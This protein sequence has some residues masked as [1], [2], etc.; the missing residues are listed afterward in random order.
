MSDNLSK[1]S[2]NLKLSAIRRT[3]L[4][5]PF[6]R[7]AGSIVLINILIYFMRPQY[8][9]HFLAVIRLNMIWSFIVFLL[10]LS[11]AREHWST[12]A[13]AMLAFLLFEGAVGFIGKIVWDPL[14]RND[15]QHFYTWLDLSQQYLSL[16]FPS[17]VLL[18]Y[19]INLLRLKLIL[20]CLG[21]Y[22]GIYSITHTGHGPGGFLWDEND[23]CLALIMLLPFA[24]SSYTANNKRLTTI[25]AVA[26][27]VSLLA[28]I[29]WTDSR[30]GFVGLIAALGYMLFRSHRKLQTIIVGIFILAT[31][32]FFVPSSYWKEMATIQQTDSGT[33]AKRKNLWK[34]A[35]RIWL[36]PKNFLTGVG[37]MNT[38]YVIADYEPAEN[39]LNRG[40]S[41]AGRAV[42]SLYFQLAADLGLIGL[43]YFAYIVNS[44][45]KRNRRGL[46][47]S[48]ETLHEL[49]KLKQ[50]NNEHFL[51][52]YFK[53]LRYELNNLSYLQ[54]AT[55]IAWVGVL[56]AGLFISVT[57]YPVIWFLVGISLTLNLYSKRLNQALKECF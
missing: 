31:A 9:I 56:F 5:G 57:Y 7:F 13:K 27:V 25:L 28:G 32:S 43:L 1:D 45:I 53:T 3:L 36:D 22:L 44:S 8:D 17:I 19:G 10:W 55:N 42:H 21:L 40:R 20:I 11:R 41:A 39:K 2:H 18:S 29:V 34:I 54:N 30:G 52:P 24:L 46:K 4:G 6:E 48:V 26:S 15:Y 50:A 14:I 12:P 16:V 35:T 51:I 38:Q 49:E 47:L 33:A 23:N 37:M